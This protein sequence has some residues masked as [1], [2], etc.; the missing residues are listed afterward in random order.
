MRIRSI[1]LAS[2]LVVALL[3]VSACHNDGKVIDKHEQ[4]LLEEDD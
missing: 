1:I 4:T 3:A 2:L